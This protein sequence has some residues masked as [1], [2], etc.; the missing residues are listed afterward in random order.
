MIDKEIIQRRAEGILIELVAIGKK[1]SVLPL[2][3]KHPELLTQI[4]TEQFVTN[5]YAAELKGTV[6]KEYTK[7][8]VG[9]IRD[10]TTQAVQSK[11]GSPGIHVQKARGLEIAG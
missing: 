6:P 9:S 2:L 4:L 10:I 7:E 1:A 3:E 11:E 8:L 5:A